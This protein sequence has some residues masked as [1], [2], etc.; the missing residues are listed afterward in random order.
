MK[1]RSFI[2]WKSCLFLDLFLIEE[3]I[4][5]FVSTIGWKEWAFDTYAVYYLY[6][7]M[8]TNTCKPIN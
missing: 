5:Q 7:S 1:I 8:T 2:E 4:K 3:D 6:V